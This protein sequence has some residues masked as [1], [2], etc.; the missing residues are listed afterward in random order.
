MCGYIRE[1]VGMRDGEKKKTHWEGQTDR[2]RERTDRER[3]RGQRERE[4]G[5]RERERTERERE[6]TAET[7][8]TAAATATERRKNRYR[9]IRHID[10]GT[11]IHR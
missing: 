7:A 2:E 11:N 1:T 3:E 5:Q 9:N 4:R 10:S 6:R 8:E